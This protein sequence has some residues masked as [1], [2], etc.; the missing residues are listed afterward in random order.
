MDWLDFDFNIA[1]RHIGSHGLACHLPL[2][3][4]QYCGCM[5]SVGPVLNSRVGWGH[6]L[7]N[8]KQC[9]SATLGLIDG[10]CSLVQ[11][12][13]LYEQFHGLL[14][15]KIRMTI[16]QILHLKWWCSRP[17]LCTLF[18]LNWAKQTLGI[19]RR[20]SWRNLP[21]SGFELATQWSEAQ[22]ATAGLRRP[23]QILHLTRTSCHDYLSWIRHVP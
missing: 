12:I 11:N 16:W 21:R 2:Q 9:F 13:I 14:I 17:L 7:K 22:H 6:V 19:M 5:V 20:N 15:T 1:L 10:E 4:Y 23:P 3:W 8:K 18:R